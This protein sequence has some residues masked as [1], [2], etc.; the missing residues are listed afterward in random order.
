MLLEQN[1]IYQSPGSSYA[2][3]DKLECFDVTNKNVKCGTG[4]DL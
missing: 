3:E 1:V 4:A 2:H